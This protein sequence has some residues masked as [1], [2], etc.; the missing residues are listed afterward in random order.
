[1]LAALL[2]SA[3]AP[4][5]QVVDGGSAPENVVHRVRALA[6]RRVLVVDAAEMDLA[7]GAVRLV[8][9]R[10]IAEQFIMSTHD[11]PVSFLIASLR[12]TV[13]DVQFLGV[14]PD[15]V[16]FGYPVTPAVARAVDDIHARLRAG[17]DFTA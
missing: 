6:P 3:P 15:I 14:Q 16:A 12:E 10:T 8:D 5:W 4:G 1:M 17:E 11:M 13:A 7:P 2:Q 9:D